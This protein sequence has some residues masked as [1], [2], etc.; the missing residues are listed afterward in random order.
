M[1]FFIINN[2]LVV[3]IRLSRSFSTQSVREVIVCEPSSVAHR[4][5]F[6]S[7]TV[8]PRKFS[9]HIA[10][11]R[12]HIAAPA[13]ATANADDG[14]SSPTFV[15]YGRGDWSAGVRKISWLRSFTVAISRSLCRVSFETQHG[16]LV[17]CRRHFLNVD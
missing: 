16:V 2:E 4:H 12:G 9:N 5:K 8:L 1:V 17:I 14:L 7:C 13:F 6:S 15:R 3:L 10:Y 11:C